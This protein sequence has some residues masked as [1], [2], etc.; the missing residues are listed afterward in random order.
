[1]IMINRFAVCLMAI[2]LLTAC[3]TT[4]VLG[5]NNDEYTPK[6]ERTEAATEPVT[7][8]VVERQK[9]AQ[10]QNVQSTLEGSNC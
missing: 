10:P 6:A 1:M 2:A 9:A 7:E 8:E 4:S 5:K 3:A